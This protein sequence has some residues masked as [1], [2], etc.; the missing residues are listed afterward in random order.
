MGDIPF[1]FQATLLLHGDFEKLV[2]RK[3]KC[4][5]SLPHSLKMFAAK[6]Q[7]WNRDTLG[8]IFK[9]KKQK[10]AM[11]GGLQH[12]LRKQTTERLLKL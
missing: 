2:E 4:E 1:R 6:L 7:A 5:D 3:W 11:A 10:S 12:V 9:R 8:N